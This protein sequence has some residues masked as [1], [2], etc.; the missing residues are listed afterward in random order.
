MHTVIE[1]QLKKGEWMIEGRGLDGLLILDT[2]FL[3]LTP[4]NDVETQKHDFDCVAISGL[5]SHPFGSWQPKGKENKSWMWIR[6]GLPKALPN[7]RTLLF[8]YDTTLTK[9]DLFQ[10]IA[11]ICFILHRESKDHGLCVIGDEANRVFSRQ[12]RIHRTSILAINENHSDVVKFRQGDPNCRVVFGK[13]GEIC[14]AYFEREVMGMLA[15]LGRPPGRANIGFNRGQLD[16]TLNNEEWTKDLIK[17]LKIP[18]RDERLAM[19]EEN[20]QHT[21]NWIFDETATPFVKWLRRQDNLFWIYGMPGSGKST[22]MKFIYRGSHH[23]LREL[24]H[25]LVAGRYH[26]QAAFFFHDR[27]TLLQKSFEGLLRSILSQ[28]LEQQN[29]FL[30]LQEL[31]S[32]ALQGKRLAE[33]METL[34]GIPASLEQYYT[35]IIDRIPDRLR[36]DAYAIFEVPSAISYFHGNEVDLLESASILACSL[37]ET[38]QDARKAAANVE[39]ELFPKSVANAVVRNISF[40]LDGV[41][42]IQDKKKSVPRRLNTN[43]AA[44]EALESRILTATAKFRFISSIPKHAF[45]SIDIGGQTVKSRALMVKLATLPER[46]TYQKLTG[47]INGPLEFSVWA[48]L[49]LYLE[50]SLRRNPDVFRGTDEDLI[51]VWWKVLRGDFV[52][53][54]SENDVIRL[55]A[56][57]IQNGYEQLKHDSSFGNAMIA[58]EDGLMPR[59]LLP[60]LLVEHGQD[61]DVWLPKLDK[62]VKIFGYTPVKAIRLVNSRL[63]KTLPSTARILTLWTVLVIP[64]WTIFLVSSASQRMPE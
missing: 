30:A 57:A 61:P 42:P 17:S 54:I 12:S 20:Y 9:S 50:E 51:S 53:R 26:I 10:T 44:L 64:P 3:G 28:I 32:G 4:P 11:D 63:M 31:T 2:H 48:R 6:D 56:V 45:K 14:A 33:L 39:C 46:Q 59:Q 18:E 52:G 19:I 21:F 35:R 47:V 58:S 37:C 24:L 7:V 43:G 8:G 22:L 16:G 55:S 49:R 38:Y 36:W 62:L 23:S 5:A 41:N 34:Q 60:S 29:D 25:D 27:G 15:G 1:T 40:I 13:L